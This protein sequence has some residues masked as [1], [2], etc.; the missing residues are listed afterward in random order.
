MRIVEGTG[1]VPVIYTAHHASSE[2]GEFLERT[3]LDFEKRI[4][5]SD[6]GTD[7]TVPT[8][9]IVTIIAEHSRALGDLNRDPDDPD[10]FKTA[11]YAKPDAHP[12]WKE[13]ESLTAADKTYCQKT[14]YDPFHTEIL[15]QLRHR[16]EPTLVVAWDNTSHYDIGLNEAGESV[17]MKPFV[18]SN[19]GSEASGKAGA[20]EPASCDP[21]LLELLA[22]QFRSELDKHDLPNEVHLNLVFKGGYITRQYS[23]FRNRSVLKKQGIT[24]EVQSL[25]LEYDTAITHNQTTLEPNEDNMIKLQTAFSEAIRITLAAYFNVEGALFPRQ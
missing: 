17:T 13:G 24:C 16:K 5:F 9:G 8:N 11:D 21:E 10:R 25:Q 12:I 15:D 14:F 19:R 6:Y 20:N 2:F 23:S 3:A 22:K 1:D 4:R 18:L 7:E